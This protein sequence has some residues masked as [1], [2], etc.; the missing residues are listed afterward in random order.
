V[1]SILE[2]VACSMRPGPVSD[3]VADRLVSA[4]FSPGS[5]ERIVARACIRWLLEDRLAAGSEGVSS[6]AG[7]LLRSAPDAVIS[8]SVRDDLW[9]LAESRAARVR[10]EARRVA[11]PAT[12]ES[13]LC[14]AVASR[15]DGNACSS[16][17]A[18]RFEA[19][20]LGAGCGGLLAGGKA[21]PV[22]ERCRFRCWNREEFR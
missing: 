9:D 1:V 2:A 3:G 21:I 13:L 20:R 19:A 4:A 16:T 14:Q 11:G 12:I 6:M 18:V 8:G 22:R 17:R 10:P 5:G 15:D 7:A